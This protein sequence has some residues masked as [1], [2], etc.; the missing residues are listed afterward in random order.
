MNNDNSKK[1]NFEELAE[2]LV[3]LRTRAITRQV[4]LVLYHMTLTGNGTVKDLRSLLGQM[5]ADPLEGVRF[6]LRFDD[7]LRSRFESEKGAIIETFIGEIN[8]SIDTFRHEEEEEMPE[9]YSQIR[10]DFS[11]LYGKNSAW[12]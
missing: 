7:S 8:E 4:L 10:N 11:Q 9:L 6:I 5:A 3:A 2:R 12:N 1:A